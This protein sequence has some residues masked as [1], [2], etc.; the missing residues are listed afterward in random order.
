MRT[1]MQLQFFTAAAINDDNYDDEY[2][3]DDDDDDDIAMRVSTVLATNLVNVVISTIKQLKRVEAAGNA[4]YGQIKPSASA[5]SFVKEAT[6]Q[7]SYLA[8]GLMLAKYSLPV[9]RNLMS[10]RQ[11]MN[12]N[13]APFSILGT[14]GAFGSV[15]KERFEVIV[16]GTQSLN[17]KAPESEWKEYEFKAKPGPLKRRPPFFSP[18]HY[19]LD[20]LMWFAAF[21]PKLQGYGRDE[22]LASFAQKL[23]QNDKEVLGLLRRNP[24]PEN[25]PKYIRMDRY[26]YRYAPRNSSAEKN[27]QTWI[28]E[29]RN[30]YLP[31]QRLGSREHGT[32]DGD[33]SSSISVSD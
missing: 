13:V 25:P 1:M 12:S 5:S 17:P 20:W 7:L 27:G 16:K 29:Y 9:V 11:V 33:S 31:P 8:F 30:L 10:R 6:S 2:D 26:R 32:L 23:L 19:R 4:Y 3:D 18:Y 24:F 22:W 15:T 14:Y 21:S 28:R